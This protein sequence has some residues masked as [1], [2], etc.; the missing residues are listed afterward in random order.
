MKEPLRKKQIQTC[1]SLAF[2]IIGACFLADHASLAG[3]N[4]FAI[5]L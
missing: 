4:C 1:Q 2:N 5:I 3:N